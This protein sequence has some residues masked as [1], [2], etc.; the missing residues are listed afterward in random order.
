[1]GSAESIG[2]RDDLFE[3]LSKKWLIYRHTGVAR[4]SAVDFPI[5]PG[6]V[7]RSPLLAAEAA[8]WSDPV[9]LGPLAQQVLLES[10]AP[11]S[12]LIDRTY[13][14]LYFYGPTDRYLKQP[15][16]AP[17]DDLIARAREGLQ[18][19]LRSVLYEAKQ[20]A[21]AVTLFEARIRHQE[22]QRLAKVMVRPVTLPK[23]PE[24]LFLVRFQEQPDPEPQRA[25]A[26]M[27]D[28]SLLGQLEEDLK[29][30][31]D[32]LQRTI[33]QQET[34]TEELRTANEEVMTVNEEL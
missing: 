27:A 34:S 15:S 6:K 29:D 22:E 1:M 20:G 24:G 26:P 23:L 16:G 32:E 8:L 30:T 10:Y 3:P 17:T 2:R 31:Q 21:K 33:E 12:V 7:A 25:C 13:Q 5:L 19:K 14:I 28:E 18:T 9:R 4:R 11:P